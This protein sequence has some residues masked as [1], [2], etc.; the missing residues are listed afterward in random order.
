MPLKV[1]LIQWPFFNVS[2]VQRERYISIS[3]VHELVLIIMGSLEDLF[4]NEI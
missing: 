3:A 4:E 1:K 2:W